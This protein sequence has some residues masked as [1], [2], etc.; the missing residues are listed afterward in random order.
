MM[1][2]VLTKEQLSIAKA[3]GK[4]QIRQVL[5]GVHITPKHMEATAGRYAV[6]VPFAEGMARGEDDEQIN[7]KRVDLEDIRKGMRSTKS[8]PGAIQI[9][10]N[11]GLTAEVTTYQSS[12]N[13][14]V[15][16]ERLDEDIVPVKSTSTVQAIEG[17]FPN[18]DQ[19]FPQDMPE[20]EK[21]QKEIKLEHDTKYV[22]VCVDAR[23]LIELLESVNAKN[24]DVFIPTGEATSIIIRGRFGL[25]SGSPAFDAIQMC[26]KI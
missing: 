5:T 21:I 19:I 23:M 4:D 1:D 2:V 15:D 17:K 18:L 7:V 9:K 25:D 20:L 6:R 11:G 10:S 16:L 22:G 24:V 13:T 8:S 3:A 12:Y 14:T 26:V